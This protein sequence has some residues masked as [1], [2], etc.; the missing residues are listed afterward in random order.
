MNDNSKPRTKDVDIIIIHS[1]GEYVGDTFASEFL[2][3]IGLSAHLFVD[4]NGHIYFGL[5]IDRVAYHVGKSRWMGREFLNGTS[6]GIEMLIKGHH[7]WSTFVSA[8]QKPESF[9]DQHYERTAKIC[10][11]TMEI[12]P[13][14][15]K[16]RIL[17]HSDVSGEDVRDD[18]KIDP[19]SGFD[20]DR[21]KDLI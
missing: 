2:E 21:L 6:I 20:M 4:H 9:T 17:R 16:S 12:Y 14:I 7:S 10:R 19:G 8:I 13:K 3:S 5:N 1:M 15:T 11:D 18:P